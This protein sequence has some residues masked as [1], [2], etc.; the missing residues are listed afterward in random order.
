MAGICAHVRAGGG[1]LTPSDISRN[2]VLGEQH[3]L[4]EL[5]RFYRI[6]IAE[7]DEPLTYEQV[8]ELL[9]ERGAVDFPRYKQLLDLIIHNVN[10][11][12]ELYR[13]REP[14]VFGG[15][16]TIFSAERVESDLGS[17][18]RQAWRPYVTGDITLYPIDCRHEEILT[19]SLS[20]YGEQLKHSF[21]LT[22]SG[23]SILSEWARGY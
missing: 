17:S 8:E 16:M 21:L 18:L 10:S 19:E 22:F 9:R 13:P 14:G 23:S 11:S 4:E 6:N 1:G 5:L 7:Q 12:I 2:H 3:V 20:M 15:D